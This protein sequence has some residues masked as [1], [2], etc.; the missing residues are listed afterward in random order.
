MELYRRLRSHIELRRLNEE[1][2]T[3]HTEFATGDERAVLYRESPTRYL[4]Y[5]CLHAPMEA[6]RLNA[7][8]DNLWTHSEPDPQVRRLYL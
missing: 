4:G 6:R 2:E 7:D 5:L 1:T 3:S 8:F